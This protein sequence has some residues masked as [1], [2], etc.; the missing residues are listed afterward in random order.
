[1]IGFGDFRDGPTGA[2]VRSNSIRKSTVE[3]SGV[4]LG[5]RRPSETELLICRRR[6]SISCIRQH[7]SDSESEDNVS[8]N[9]TGALVGQEILV[10]TVRRESLLIPRSFE[11]IFIIYTFLSYML[12]HNI[13]DFEIRTAHCKLVEEP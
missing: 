10:A 12:L 1:M 7:W 6:K 4:F 8:P 2:G 9:T 13:I 11:E 5:T 3:Y